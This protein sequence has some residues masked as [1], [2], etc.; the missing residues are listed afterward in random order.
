[1]ARGYAIPCE[2]EEIFFYVGE[3]SGWI[4]VKMKKGLRPQIE[5]AGTFL[6]K[7]V[8]LTKFPQHW[9]KRFQRIRSR[10]FH[11]F[12]PVPVGPST[13]SLSR[14]GKA[15]PSTGARGCSIVVAG[16]LDAKSEFLYFDWRQ[17]QNALG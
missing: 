13:L 5:Q 16:A 15:R 14:G 3:Y 11:H 6:D 12:A 1:M 7:K 8:T 4:F 9:V 17:I 2:R 10:V